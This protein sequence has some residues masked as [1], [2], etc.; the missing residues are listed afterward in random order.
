MTATCETSSQVEPLARAARTVDGPA[1]DVIGVVSTP[2]IIPVVA[3]RLTVCGNRPGLGTITAL[4]IV[5]L[6]AMAAVELTF[7]LG[8]V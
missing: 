3:G 1:N 4:A 6:V 8:L 5:A 2:A 7:V